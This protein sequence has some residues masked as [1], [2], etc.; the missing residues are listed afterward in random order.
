MK[1]LPTKTTLFLLGLFTW[2]STAIY[3]QDS[4]GD[5]HFCNTTERLEEMRKHHPD[6]Y[7][8]YVQSQKELQEFTEDFIKTYDPSERS[9]PY[10]IPVVFHVLHTFGSENISDA[11]IY[12]AMRVMNEDFNKL[13]NDWDLVHPAFVDIVADAGV[14]F[15]L[16]QR[17]PNGNCHKGITRT[18][19][20]AT[21]NDEGWFPNNQVQAVQDAHGNW[22]GNRYMNVFVVAN[23]G[24]AA[25]YTTLPNFN[26]SM[27]NGIKLLHNYVGQIGTGSV[28]LSRAL[29]HEVGHWLNLQ[30]PWG[31]SNNPGLTNNC[32]DDDGVADTPNTIGWTVCN[33][34]GESCGSLDNVENYMEYSYCSKMFTQGQKTRMI[35]ALNSSTGGRNNL[36]SSGNLTFTGTTGS[37]LLCQADFSTPKRIVCVG[38][39]VQYFDESFHGPTGRSWTF[40]GG[41]PATSTTTNPTVTYSTPGVYS[42]S[43]TSTQGSNNVSTTRQGYITVL[44]A[45]GDMDYLIDDFESLNDIESSTSWFVGHEFQ[46]ANTWALNTN[47]GFESNK[48]I[49]INNHA[50]SEGRR[51]NITSKTVDLSNVSNAVLSFDYAYARRA[52]SDEDELVVFLSTTCGESW[53]LAR[54]Y[55]AQGGQFDLNTANQT[56]SSFIPNNSQWKHAEIE[57]PESFLTENFQVRFQFRSGGGNNVFVDNVN[58]IDPA[59][60]SSENLEFENSRVNVFPNPASDL[61]NFEFYNMDVETLH[62]FDMTGRIVESISVRRTQLTLDISSYNSGMYIYQLIDANGNRIKTDRLSIVR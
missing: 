26:T 61:V 5:V 31:G 37:N 24:G 44:P 19:T 27:S 18:Y 22:P 2:I 36:W 49:W 57:L 56:S 28:N 40:E 12:D 34:N 9:G 29:T 23:A 10:I 16:A 1:L 59:F 6:L 13:N 25:G 60:V 17:D 47:T 62:L 38:E 55:R 4:H 42:V 20:D 45:V 11:Q 35:A 41:S 46:G 51:D 3:A 54:R 53:V 32:N 33:V 50:N 15:R 21:H 48:S 30:H 52:A 58:V 8:Q 43:L 7:E 39:Q 14:E